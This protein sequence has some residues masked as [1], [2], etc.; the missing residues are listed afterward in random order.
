MSGLYKNNILPSNPTWT[1]GTGS[2]TNKDIERWY[3]HSRCWPNCI[4]SCNW[5]VIQMTNLLKENPDYKPE[6]FSQQEI[7]RIRKKLC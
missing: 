6:R 3:G 1:P 5:V 7:D 4:E 2:Y